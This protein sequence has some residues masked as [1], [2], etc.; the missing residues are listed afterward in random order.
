MFCEHFERFPLL[1][2]YETKRAQALAD[3]AASRESCA[4]SQNTN[5][6]AGPSSAFIHAGENL[7]VLRLTRHGKAVVH[8]VDH[9]HIPRE[10]RDKR[11]A[12]GLPAKTLRRK[13]LYVLKTRADWDILK[14]AYALWVPMRRIFCVDSV[15]IE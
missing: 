2:I 6:N 15:T 13:N 12:A 9:L 5:K 4:P 7:H 1:H 8:F 10:A 11:K 3:A 14:L